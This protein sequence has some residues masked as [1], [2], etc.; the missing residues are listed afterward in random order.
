MSKTTKKTTVQETQPVVFSTNKSV[1]Q[2]VAQPVAQPVVHPV[3]HPVVQPVVHPV[4]HL[5]PE[6]EVLDE[7]AVIRQTQYEELLNK[8][9]QAQDELGT[10]KT[11]LKKFYKLVEKDV[12]KAS[13]GRRRV[14]R[15]RSPTGFGKAGIIP[16]GLCTLL[17]IDVSTEMTRPEVTKKLYEYLDAHNLRDPKDK[18]IIRT[19]AELAIAFSLTPEQIK[20]IN[21]SNDI[22]GNKGLN[23]YNIQKFVAA[24]YKG[25][26][27]NLDVGVQDDGGSGSEEEETEQNVQE[28][29]Q[30]VVK[31]VV[32]VKGKG[33]GKK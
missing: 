3:V 7:K 25:K 26:S 14:N 16:E 12:L 27:I 18:R 22:K 9:E 2:L 29:V 4:V 30:E 13:K 11:N 10:L 15:E 33:K 5:E 20:S 21:E 19:N 8:L 28:V 24:L 23:F 1:A 17:K 31:E 6:P 32:Q